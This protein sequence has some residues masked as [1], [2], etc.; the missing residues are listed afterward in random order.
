MRRLFSTYLADEDGR[1][2][3][4][5]ETSEFKNQRH[6][7]SDLARQWSGSVIISEQMLRMPDLAAEMAAAVVE[8][9]DPE[10]GYGFVEVP[11]L[12]DQAF[13][14]ARVL[15]QS[16]FGDVLDGDDLVCDVIRTAKGL[17]VSVVHVV[18][19]PPQRTYKA[20]IVKLFPDRRYGFMSIP[21]LA[22]EAFFHYHL[23]PS[24]DEAGLT[25]SQIFL[26]EIKTDAQSRS[27]VRRIVD[28][29]G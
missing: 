17:S 7:A 10:K 19:Q 23:F 3:T 4:V 24:A 22:L 27:Q 11:S 21:E 2:C 1:L 5:P 15:E 26:I 20:E 8:T 6:L 18:R 12:R 14:H 25:E 28:R 29:L 13:L 9:F 16:G